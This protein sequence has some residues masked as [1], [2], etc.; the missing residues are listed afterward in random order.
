LTP[1]AVSM[2]ASLRMRF[3]DPLQSRPAREA[4]FPPLP[5]RFCSRTT[6]SSGHAAISIASRHPATKKPIR[7]FRCLLRP[8]DSNRART[9]IWQL[10]ASADPRKAEP[11][12]TY[13]AWFPAP[14]S[15]TRCPPL[16]PLAQA[17]IAE[18]EA[19]RTRLRARIVQNRIAK[20]LAAAAALAKA[21][22]H[23]EIH[24]V[25]PLGGYVGSRCYFVR[26][27]A[28]RSDEVAGEPVLCGVGVRG[29]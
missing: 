2:H 16:K 24:A 18:H 9:Q 14:S 28:P 17:A 22:Q 8:V 26:S 1:C 25:T 13:N 5:R 7:S 20:E 21:I 19:K 27:S 11:Q 4:T 23:G 29:L 10:F 6:A 3:L 15:V 12:S